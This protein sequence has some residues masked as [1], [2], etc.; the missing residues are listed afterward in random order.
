MIKLLA[1]DLDD[2]LLT[3]ELM[4]SGENQRAIRAAEAAGVKVLLA[5]GRTLFSMRSYGLRLGMWQNEGFMIANNGATVLNTQNGATI[6][7]K[8][9]DPSIGLEA[10]KIVQ[11]YDLTMQYYG[12]G[13]IFCSGPSTYTEE[14]CRLTGQQW[15]ESRPF[16]SSLTSPRTKFVVPGDPAIL[17]RLEAELK[18][19][20]GHRANIFISKPYFLEILSR[21]ADKGIALAFVAEKLSI[22]TQQV[23][24][25]GD[26][27]NDYGML[28]WAGVGVAVANAAPEV[29]KVA[30]HITSRSH[31]EHAV[32]E[33]I[34]RFIPEALQ[35]SPF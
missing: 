17:P 11:K 10:W 6:L 19:Q 32:A 16:S 30:D 3:E 35:P 22:P 33:A 2:T 21:D 25:V 14:D 15:R 7:E 5:S 26:S 8:Q 4:I 12:D 18:E 24:A 1:L 20:L 29:L 23:M 34:E 27:M 9:L 31:Q 13:E 28:K